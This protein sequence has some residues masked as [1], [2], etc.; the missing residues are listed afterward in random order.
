MR[1]LTP[2]FL[3]ALLVAAA[4]SGDDDDD[5]AKPSST[6]SPTSTQ[7]EASETED[8]SPT[9]ESTTFVFEVTNSPTKRAVAF[10]H[11]AEAVTDILG[12]YA[13]TFGTGVVEPVPCPYEEADGVI[14]C[15]AE[16]Y[17]RIALDI[18]PTGGVTECR[19]LLSPGGDLVAAGCSTDIPAGY[20]Y[21]IVE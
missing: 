17:G 15:T 18:L 6:E 10:D 5:T 14:N 21:K 2:L 11:Y 16:G 1:F 8:S 19:A 7:A 12:Y 20:F 3:I 13:S 9:P 4:C